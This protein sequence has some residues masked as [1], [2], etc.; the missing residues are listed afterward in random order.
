MNKARNCLFLGKIINSPWTR[1]RIIAEHRGQFAGLWE[2][3]GLEHVEETSLEIQ[4]EFASFDDYWPPFLQGATPMGAYVKDLAPEG[5]EALR[6]ALRKRFLPGGEDGPFKL[7]VRA[8]AVRGT[9]P[10]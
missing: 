9:V 2:A 8:W 3:A 1:S 4:V 6:E 7:G 5:R 10:R